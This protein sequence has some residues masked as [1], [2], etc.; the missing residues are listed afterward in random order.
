MAQEQ[1]PVLLWL[2]TGFLGGDLWCF[3][4][5]LSKNM[6]SYMYIKM[7]EITLGTNSVNALPLFHPGAVGSPAALRS[8]D[9]GERGEP[10]TFVDC[11]M[12]KLRNI[13]SGFLNLM[14]P[15][16]VYVYSS[17][18]LS[19]VNRLNPS[20]PPYLPTSHSVT[21]SYKRMDCLTDVSRGSRDVKRTQIEVLASRG[22]ADLPLNSSFQ[23]STN[24]SKNWTCPAPTCQRCAAARLH[25]KTA[26]VG[27]CDS[28]NRRWAS[29]ILP[30]ANIGERSPRMFTRLI[31]APLSSR[32]NH[33]SYYEH[34]RVL[35]STA[36]PIY[37]SD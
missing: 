31:S 24:Q 22:K 30:T 15:Q 23:P 12:N 29:L 16:L 1:E 36:S 33:F 26:P 19:L 20:T 3:V 34:P 37:I 9:L 28:P 32:L 11:R 25:I 4:C 7:N 13:G 2:A 21:D 5:L 17:L 27:S 35:R 6:R 10:G 18:Y 14:K 8:R